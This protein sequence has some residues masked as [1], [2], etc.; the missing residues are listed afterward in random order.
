MER[1][2]NELSPH[3][4]PI[5][6]HLSERDQLNSIAV[7]ERHG[8]D[9]SQDGSNSGEGALRAWTL[10][11]TSRVFFKYRWFIALVTFIGLFLA[12]AYAFFATPK[13]TAE[14]TLK[15]GTYA[16][17]LPGAGLEDTMRQQTREQDYLNTQVSLLS[18]LS[19]ADKVYSD[20]DLNLPLTEYFSRQTGL[21]GFLKPF[22]EHLFGT[23][24]ET[25]NS[26]DAVEQSYEN[27]INRLK[28]YL[29]IVDIQA[30]RKTALV[31][32]SATTSS[33][34]L[35]ASVANT[36]AQGFIDL[37][38]E[39]RQNSTLE[40]LLFLKRQSQELADQLAQSER[41]L[42]AY[43]EENAI[44][45]VNKDEN[46]VVRRM[47][48][49]NDLLTAATAKRITAES[50]FNESKSGSGIATSA[51]DDDSIQSL[52]LALKKAESDYSSLGQKFK[53][54]YPRM[55]QLK[56]SIDSLR[57]NIKQQRGQMLGALEADYE[58]ALAAERALQEQ[59][60]MQKSQ[61]FELARRE[62]QFNIM[63]RDYESI[64][65][66]HQSVL[67]QLKEAQVSAE[68]S[69]TNVSIA[70][71]AAVP[72]G[73]SSPKKLRS[74]AL[75]LIAGFILGVGLA[76][77]FELFDNT[78]KTPE[79]V[80][81]S[82]RVPSLGVI[83]VFDTEE[84]NQTFGQEAPGSH[85]RLEEESSPTLPNEM[86]SHALVPKIA[87]T[88]EVSD[89][90][91]ASAPRSIASESFRSV[92]TAILLSSADNP[93][94]TIMVTSAK[95]SEG[96]TTLVSNLALTL[97]QAS[98][99]V[100]VIDADLRRPSL[101]TRFNIDPNNPG[102][103]DYLTSLKPIEDVVH[104]TEVPTLHVISCGPLPPNPAE[105]IGSKKMATLLS[106]LS[107][108]YD[109]VL[110]DTP[111][112]LPVTDAVMLSRSVDGVALV[113]RGQSTLTPLARDAVNRIK[114]AGANLLGVVLNDV[115]IKSGD[116]QYYYRDTYSY[117]HEDD[118]RPKKRRAFA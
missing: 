47:S 67:R 58:S 66:L 22:K 115:N 42:A 55:R 7:S 106:D 12:S 50:R 86:N 45:S 28:G 78:L 83:P 81:R 74:L 76:I 21:F 89:L 94:R 114:G 32:I 100:I 49:L 88:A 37:I 41:N 57:E 23:V 65:D 99:K 13:F 27:P 113:V 39:D 64:Q 112:V 54:G 53:P 96:K 116:Y 9:A 43:A 51:N 1:N 98:S 15:I 40:N 16:P 82:L 71:K 10:D 102:L 92:R 33:A 36:H 62:V 68:S 26:L 24:E 56:A 38:R 60:D 109:Y 104:Q 107:E 18:G 30:I 61:A 4:R 6:T 101:H 5:P 17:L 25:D 105:L 95:K 118:E 59:L 91:V 75:G 80:Q 84:V 8:F 77:M 48:E 29:N 14:A 35:S 19:L 85:P 79:D 46:I 103:V 63:K 3:V 34:E 69:G 90:V 72:S 11:D 52:R 110:I 117:Y 20:P 108:M 93:P 97:A 31:K 111:P 73:P 2:K 87:D 44:V 70:D